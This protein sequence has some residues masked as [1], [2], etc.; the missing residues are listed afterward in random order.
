MG[1]RLRESLTRALRGSGTPGPEAGKTY[2]LRRVRLLVGI[3]VLLGVA[4]GVGVLTSTTEPRS[5]AVTNRVITPGTGHVVRVQAASAGG[6]AISG[7]VEQGLGCDG[8]GMVYPHSVEPDLSTHVRPGTGP[9]LAGSTWDQVPR[10]FG[11]APA[12]PVSIVLSLT[13]SAKHSV[14][15]TGVTLNVLQRRPQVVGPWVNRAQNCGKAGEFRAA[16]A[17]LDRPAPYYVPDAGFRFPVS[18][19]TTDT[20]PLRVTVRTESCDC[21]WDATVHW[22]DAGKEMSTV[23]DDHGHPFE[24]T[25]VTGQHGVNWVNVSPAADRDSGWRTRPLPAG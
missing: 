6:A 17:D 16:V 9:R 8:R 7:T 12:G 5:G 10:A 19:S 15:V 20:K 23:V 25:S 18:L 14:T 4:A 24:T 3:A 13:G 22:S 2:W 1:D 21:M 11:A